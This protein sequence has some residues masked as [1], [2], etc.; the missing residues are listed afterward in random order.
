MSGEILDRLLSKWNQK[1][2]SKRCS[3]VFLMDNAGFHPPELKEA[4][5]NIKQCFPQIKNIAG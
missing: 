1:L 3:V 2:R 5:T 4:Y